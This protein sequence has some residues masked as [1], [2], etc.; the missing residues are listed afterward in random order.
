MDAVCFLPSRH[1]FPALFTDGISRMPGFQNGCGL[2]SF[3]QRSAGIRTGSRI[4]PHKSIHSFKPVPNACASDWLSLR[5]IA[6][7]ARQRC[8]C[9]KTLIDKPFTGYSSMSERRTWAAEAEGS[10]PSTRTTLR[11]TTTHHKEKPSLANELSQTHV[12]LT[13]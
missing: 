13:G 10:I 6:K 5:A 2:I 1:M 9:A 4:D 7:A 11:C 8:T 12:H 3:S